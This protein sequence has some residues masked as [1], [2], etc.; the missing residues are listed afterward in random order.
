[1]GTFPPPRATAVMTAA[2]LLL[3]PVLSVVGLMD[4][5][6]YPVPIVT[7]TLTPTQLEAVVTP[8]Q[9]GPVVFGG[10]ASVEM[11]SFLTVTVSLSASCLWPAIISP[12]T[13]TFDRSMTQKFS[14]TVV[15]PPRTSSLFVGTLL[16]SAT[17]KAP[18]IAL[19]TAS[20]SAVVTVRQYFGLEA[21]VLGGPFEGVHA[22]GTVQ[23]RLEVNNTGNGLDS[24][25]LDLLDPNGLISTCDMLRGV[26]IHQEESRVVPFTL[27][28]NGSLGPMSNLSREIAFVCTSTEAKD[29]GSDCTI[30]VWC[31]L[32]FGTTPVSPAEGAPSGGGGGDGSLES[33]GDSG[34]FPLALVVLVALIVVLSVI[35]A[36]LGRKREGRE[37]R[38]EMDEGGEPDQ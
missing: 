19:Q 11:L 14:V 18:G 37:W 9:N 33:S 8:S 25:A 20:A 7:L 2:L 15:V 27:Y 16:V 31:T 28:V 35:I 3:G 12:S 6:I 29:L 13:M 24:V 4:A 30:T 34:G 26:D 32:S 38:T 1:M 23:G 17:A 5:A 21:S 22:G 36:Y 10:N